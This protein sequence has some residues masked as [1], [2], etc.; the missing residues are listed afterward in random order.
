MKPLK[1]YQ[2][3]I[4][5]LIFLCFIFFTFETKAQSNSYEFW[6]V[7]LPIYAVVLCD[8]EGD[9]LDVAFAD[10][11]SQSKVQEVLQLK[12]L[13]S[14]CYSRRP[15]GLFKV[16]E[17]IGYYEDHSKVSTVII[18]VSFQEGKETIGY[19]I[20]TGKLATDIENSL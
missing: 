18:G 11:Q 12:F 5:S 7:G 19:L 1:E 20:M 16:S 15:A 2:I 4:L 6:K 17:I 14:R 13:E 3:Y 8:H 10:S 9:I